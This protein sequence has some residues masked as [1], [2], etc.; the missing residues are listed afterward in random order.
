MERLQREFPIIWDFEQ[1]GMP[2]CDGLDLIQRAAWQHGSMQKNTK[3]H[4]AQRQGSLA[5]N[6]TTKAAL[7]ITEISEF[8]EALRSN[9]IVH[10]REEIADSVIRLLD[11]DME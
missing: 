10:A 8:I 5:L 4:E 9:N 2:F 1:N 11:L 6:L 3:F 7:A